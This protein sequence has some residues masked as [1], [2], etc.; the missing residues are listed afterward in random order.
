MLAREKQIRHAGLQGVFLNLLKWY[1]SPTKDSGRRSPCQGRHA[2]GFCEFYPQACGIRLR[3][4]GLTQ[5]VPRRQL[6]RTY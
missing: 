3:L 5:T 2:V 6:R 4:Q 1:K